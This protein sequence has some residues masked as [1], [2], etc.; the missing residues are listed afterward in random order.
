MAFTGVPGPR[1]RV[2][3]LRAP[4]VTWVG[5]EVGVIATL[6]GGEV[7]GVR[8]GTALGVAFHPESTGDDRLH[9][10]LVETVRQAGFSVATLQTA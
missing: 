8:Q 4:L 5:P 9:R 3:L 2:A 10:V 7:V 1:L 6:A